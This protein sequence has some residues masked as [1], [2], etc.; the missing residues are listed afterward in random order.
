MKIAEIANNYG[1]PHDGVGA[2]AK[3]IV[4]NFSGC[5][6][7]DVFSSICVST[8]S[9]LKKLLSRGM[10][11]EINKVQ[12]NISNYDAVI[13]D[14]PFVEWNPF[15]IFA[16]KRLCSNAHKERKK[17]IASIHEYNRVNQFRKKVIEFLVKRADL[18]LVCNEELK[19]S[20]S[21]FSNNIK[22]RDIPTN[23]YSPV[24]QCSFSRNNYVFFGLIN[25]S[26]AFDE[27]LLGWDE[28]NKRGVCHLDIITSTQ[29][30]IDTTKHNNVNITY[31]ADDN[32]IMEIM[33][34]CAF[35]ILPIIPEIDSKN[36]TFKTASIA[37]CI[38][39]GKFCKD[40]SQLD[41]VLN[42]ESYKPENFITILRE[43]RDLQR[44]EIIKKRES[45]Y[46]FGQ[47]FLPS[48]VAMKIEKHIVQLCEE[49]KSDHEI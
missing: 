8:D 25:G 6:N 47:H 2:Y 23:I 39:I 10:T 18:T 34:S 16:Y 14:Y 20:L 11:K 48:N 40:Y 21:P 12:K 7:V 17:I 38:S 9:T 37:K 31:N 32:H 13:I 1:K 29:I 22:I 26:K 5:V 4:S 49:K 19:K 45:A 15:I 28:F 33:E 41:F 30:E 27:M 24:T 44:D 43:S 42:M 35:C 36:A 46:T 3:V